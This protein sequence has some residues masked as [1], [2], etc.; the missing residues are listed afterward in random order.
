MRLI[1]WTPV[2]LAED[3]YPLEQPLTPYTRIV[4]VLHV[5]HVTRAVTQSIAGGY[6]R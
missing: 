1:G 4:Y 3:R 5:E 6:G 2:P